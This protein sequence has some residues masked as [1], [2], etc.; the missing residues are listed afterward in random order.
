MK[1]KQEYGS[2]SSAST[3]HVATFDT[4]S[5]TATCS[6][7]G[8]R[9]PNRCWHVRDIAEKFERGE[10]TAAPSARDRAREVMASDANVE[11]VNAI[12]DRRPALIAPRRIEPMLASA[13]T[14]G[15][16]LSDYASDKWIMEE[17]YDGDRQIITVAGGRVTESRSRAGN[18]RTLPADVRAALGLLPDGVYD[19][20]DMASRKTFGGARDGR[21]VVLFDVVEIM[22]ERVAHL[23]WSERRRFLEVAFAHITAQ[24]AGCTC[25]AI[26]AVQ[27][28]SAEAVAAI[29]KRGGEGA[30]IKRVSATYQ[31]GVRSADWIKVKKL[32]H[33]TCEIVGFESGDTGIAFGRTL[34]RDP[35]GVEFSVKTKDNA[36]LAQVARNPFAF[37]GKRLVVQYT[38]K[39]ET[40]RY[41][42]PM[43]D[44][45]AGD[46]E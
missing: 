37:V 6:C 25:V 3:K 16:V 43:F 32:G 31:F 18:T 41:R 33:V 1:I 38:E 35:D 26:T 44:H 2:R 45:F 23:P 36:T 7:R 19:G 12:H 42:H 9:S 30:I 8:F 40:G 39:L 27:P 17:K 22:G 10:L 11:R 4:D 5:R 29:W 21:I 13:M 14:K 24:D 20:E 15:L 34:L 46:A 28:V